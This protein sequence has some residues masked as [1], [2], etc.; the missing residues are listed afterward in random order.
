MIRF[1][2]NTADSARS[3]AHRANHF[4]VV[5][6][7]NSGS[8][9]EGF[10]A[11]VEIL[12]NHRTIHRSKREA[13]K[14]PPAPDMRARYRQWQAQSHEG[15]RRGQH[16]LAPVAAQN[17]H[18]S[19]AEQ[20][21]CW[22]V[23]A[24]K[25]EAYCKDWFSHHAFDQLRDRMVK[26]I[27]IRQNASVPIIIHSDG[28]A[29]QDIL[30]RLPYHLWE[31]D[32]E[33]PNRE[34]ALFNQY[35]RAEAPLKKPLNVLAIFGSS[36]GGL[37]LE[38]DATALR[39][40]RRNGARI[41]QVSEPDNDTLYRLLCDHQWDILCFAG[42]SSSTE[43]GGQIQIR[44]NASLRLEDLR[45][46]LASA[47]KNGLKLAIF[48]SCDGLGIADF[49]TQA[50]IQNIIVM[51]EPVPDD[52]A[53]LFLKIFLEEFTRGCPLSQALLRARRRLAFEQGAFP[54]ASWLPIAYLNPSAPDLVLPP[55]AF[56]PLSWLRTQLLGMRRQQQLWALGLAVTLAV[57]GLP[58]VV[59]HHCQ[60]APALFPTCQ[61]LPVEGLISSGAQALQGSKVV[62]SDSYYS[63]K[64]KGIESFAKGD[65]ADAVNLF[66][67]LR[68]QA[69][70]NKAAEGTA[71]TTALAALQDPEVL[72]YRNNALVKKRQADHLDQQIYTIAVAAPLNNDPGMNIVAGVA[73][74]QDIA[75][76]RGVNLMVMIA[77]DGNNREQA[78]QIAQA[79][80]DNPDIL[81]VVGH[82]T[83]PNTCEALKVYSPNKLVLIAPTSTMVN[84]P[85]NCGDGQSRIFFRTVSSTRIEAITLVEYLTQDLK[86]TQPKIVVFY[87]SQELFSQDMFEQFQEVSKSY[88]ADVIGAFD[89]SDASFNT[90][91]LPPQ[92]ADADALALLPDGGTDNSIA[93]NKSIRIIQL[94]NGEKPILGANTLYLQKVLTEGKEAL[95]NHLFIAVDWHPAMCGAEAFAQQIREYWGGD[96]NRRT[97]L[98]YEAV[99]VLVSTLPSDNKAMM[100]R[101]DIRQKLFDT[102]IIAGAAPASDVLEG[103]KISFGPNGDRR[104]ITTRSVAT[105]NEKGLF[106]IAKDITC[107]QPAAHTAAHTADDSDTSR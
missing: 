15:S 85:A 89:L 53:C 35:S 8:F 18:I 65:Y 105:V 69:R 40:L 32:G 57:V 107:P 21:A 54:A 77:N 17:T 26:N 86:I 38:Q 60:L 67:T 13:F 92:V 91:R 6:H 78:Q 93:L 59:T 74:A 55:A 49:L 16:R 71:R 79:L 22:K 24:E 37:N 75:V 5:L 36:A 44:Q 73:Q 80:S 88:N 4:A 42:H 50:G 48:N 1:S 51:R 90:E 11:T 66:D 62:L 31:F 23:A 27:G 84:L 2:F 72:I 76:K 33:L 94:N 96:L 81:A 103:L 10:S 99:Q 30:A 102:D 83:S 47:Q 52:I 39:S 19:D 28:S 7:I 3:A 95:I 9:A 68:S 100:T 104:E 87:N 98:A 34:F 64:A 45:Q 63:L 14:L 61:R 97:A 101:S 82:Y 56:S 29:D 58:L 12:E 41:T 46:S 70:Q 20:L 106:A 25:L 43:N